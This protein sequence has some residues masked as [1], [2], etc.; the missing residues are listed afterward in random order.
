MLKRIY[1]EANAFISVSKYVGDGVNKTVFQKP[2][3]IIPNVVDTS[4]FFYQEEKNQKFTF[5]HVSNM[6][7][8]KNVEGIIQAFYHFLQTGVDAQLIMIGNRDTYYQQLAEK[9]G[10][11]NTAIFFK[12]EIAHAEVAREMQRSHAFILNSDIENS[13]CVISEALCCGLPVI[14]TNVG[15][16]PEML[17]SRNGKLIPSKNPNALCK[18]MLELCK[19]SAYNNFQIAAKAGETFGVQVIA[20]QFHL[21][22]QFV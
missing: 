13:P 22:Y 19:S 2:Y 1:R 16:I 6:V 5:L 12:G 18:A 21:L 8:L 10:I 9:I 15:G 7:A 11:P 3:T 17:A 14:A 4:L 20:S